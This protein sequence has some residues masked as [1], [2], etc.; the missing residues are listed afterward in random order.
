MFLRVEL[1]VKLRNDLYK[2]IL[3]PQSLGRKYAVQK[4]KSGAKQ[5]FAISLRMM[6]QFLESMWLDQINFLSYTHTL[7]IL[8]FSGNTNFC[9]KNNQNLT[10][11][12]LKDACTIE[13]Y[14]S[15]VYV[16]VLTEIPWQA[17]WYSDW[18]TDRVVEDL[19]S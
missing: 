18:R 12:V 19:R 11:K 14:M 6:T 15:K 1:L 3:H 16:D 13:I 8:D 4:V 5:N 17:D 10:E 9:H 2:K 7:T